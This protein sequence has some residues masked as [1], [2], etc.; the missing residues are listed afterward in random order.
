VTGASRAFAPRWASPP[1]DTIRDALEERG[2]SREAFAE[3]IGIPISHVP[4]LLGGEERISIALAR[5][6]SS[7]IGG[8]VE[9]WLTRD[10]QY[11]DDLAL[12]DADRWAESLPTA[13][14]VQLGWIDM[15]VDWQDRISACLRFFDVRDLNEWKHTYGSMLDGARFRVSEKTASDTRAAA[16]WLRKAEIEARNINCAPWD[17]S[18]FARS[19]QEVRSLTRVSDPQKFLPKLAAICAD[20]G[21]ALVVLRTP[22]RC[23]ASGA[24]LYLDAGMPLV[25]LSARH[26]SDDHFW[27]SFF[28]EAGHVLLHAANAAYIDDLDPSPGRPIRK[29]EREADKFASDL[30]V[31]PSLRDQLFQGRPTPVRLHELSTKLGVSTG[32]LVGQLQHAGVLGYGTALNRL[33]HRYK[34]VGSNLERA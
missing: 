31:P 16:A 20:T 23:P 26:L 19:L 24:A 13:Q 30:L 9:F 12:V 27:F 15:P 10:G 32:V 18:A 14:M 34:W 21:V 28:H 6:I 25:V 11:R 7:T 8:S 17:P 2:L 33:K 22:P 4:A 29:D 3:A 5:R 1:G